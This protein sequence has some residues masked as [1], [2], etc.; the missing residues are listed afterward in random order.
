MQGIFE[1]IPPGGAMTPAEILPELWS[2]TVRGGALHKELLTP[3]T[4][5]KKMDVRVG[6]G[7]YFEPWNDGCY[8]RRAG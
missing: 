5:R 7:R 8:A 2:W 1:I 3:A 6:F 4:L